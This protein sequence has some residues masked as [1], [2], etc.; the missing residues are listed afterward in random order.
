MEAVD[1]STIP[2][3]VHSLPHNYRSHSG[4]TDLAKSVLDILSDLFPDSFDKLPDE[5]CVF[6][7]PKPV[8]LYAYSPDDLIKMLCHHKQET[9]QIEFGAHQAILVV[10]DD[11]RDKV[12]EE[13]KTGIVLTLY[14][15]KGLE[16]DDILL[17]NIFK[18]SQVCT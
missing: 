16:F 6:N 18:N 11:A 10:D 8:L 7:G 1:V 2:E 3:R 9:S 17:F 12:P 13:L 15:A 4:I 14:E 5:Q